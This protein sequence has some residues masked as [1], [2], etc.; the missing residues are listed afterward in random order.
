M[1][2]EVHEQLTTY[3]DVEREGDQQSRIVI[4]TFRTGRSSTVCTNMQL[5]SDIGARL[6]WPL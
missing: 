6:K 1:S 5:G 2:S 4:I 3:K